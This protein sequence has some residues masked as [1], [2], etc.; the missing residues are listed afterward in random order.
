MNSD[1]V[2]KYLSNAIKFLF[3][4]LG[5]IF[6]IAIFDIE[7]NKDSPAEIAKRLEEKKARLEALKSN[8]YDLAQKKKTLDNWP[9][10]MNKPYI[11]MELFDQEGQEFKISDLKGKV[12]IIEYIDMSSPVSQAQSGAGLL[13]AYAATPNQS[14]D[15]YAMPISDILPKETQ[16][17]LVLPHDDII[18]LKI[19]I[20]GEGGN[21]G[22]RDDAMNWANHFN[23]KKSD[24]V[25]VAVPKK[26]MRGKD[27]DAILTGYQLVDKNMILRV[28]A[29][30]VTPKHNLKMTLIPLIP[31]LLL[32]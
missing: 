2:Q 4:M 3:A 5:L 16:G 30:G 10:K 12:I 19:I 27:S 28:D 1:Q 20:Y 8:S 21:A 13:G 23:F 9:P 7:A 24:N 25:I 11:D 14:V 6:I 26:D 32:Q 31:K 29:A 22:S 17:S 18:Q 15:K